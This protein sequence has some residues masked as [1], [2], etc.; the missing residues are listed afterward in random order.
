MSDRTH[1]DAIVLISLP[2]QSPVL[3]A[4]QYISIIG[5]PHIDEAHVLALL[6]LYKLY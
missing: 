1:S 5:P 3:Q 2:V 6:L 4:M